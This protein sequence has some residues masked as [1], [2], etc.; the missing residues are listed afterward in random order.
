MQLNGL[1]CL[2]SAW[3]AYVV[4]VYPSVSIGE[5]KYEESVTYFYAV[6]M[7]AKVAGPI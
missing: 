7:S 4:I 3:Y 1:Y 2:Q 6:L 5:H